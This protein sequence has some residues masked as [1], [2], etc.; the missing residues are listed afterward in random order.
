MAAPCAP[1][2]PAAPWTSEPPFPFFV[3]STPCA[4][5]LVIT[6]RPV[7]NAA[8][9]RSTRA[10][11]FMSHSPGRITR[12]I[13]SV[14]IP[15]RHSADVA[16]AG[17][18][19]AGIAAALE[20][21]SRGR[22]VLL[23]D[24][25]LEENFGGLAKD[26]FGGLWFAGTPLQ[27][28]R[29]IRDD[30][31]L[32]LADWLAFGE[33]GPEHE[34]PRAWARAY[35]E[36]CVPDVYEWLSALGVQFMPMPM[37]V[38]RGLHVPGNSVPRF[39][40]VWGTGRALTE[41]LIDRLL[42]HPRRDLLELRFGH[43]V[44]SLVTRAGSR[45]RAAWGDRARRPSVRG[46]LRVG[47]HRRGRHQRRHRTRAPA[48]ACGLGR[49]AARDPERVASL[50]ERRAPRCGGERGRESHAPRLAMELRRGD[51]SLASAETRSWTL[52]RAAEIG[53]LAQ[54][55]GRAHRA[56]AAR[57]AATTRT[58][59]SRASAT[60][61]AAIAGN[62]S[63]GA[64]HSRSSPYPAPSSIPRSA[65]A[66]SSASRS[67]SSSAIAGSTRSSRATARTSSSRT[68]CRS[69]SSG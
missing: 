30:A 13:Y 39:H 45:L 25:D 57:R 58:N 64:S 48:L 46:R 24:R 17:A 19:I 40:L 65:T 11:E 22:R 23:L 63:T 54:L 32:G 20:A 44:D 16:I 47:R 9:G 60:N 4:W 68:R 41:T 62:C 5:T 52:A 42:N 69:S 3:S 12:G 49:A 10:V 14:M 1:C 15:D 29:G 50:R 61:P 66:G 31:A 59:S 67:I 6:A 37:W 18:G 7:S 21:L 36:R 43:R 33:L 38:E 56:D 8:I 34:W 26:A 2:V 35:V 27:R 55:A 28:R 51:P 53:A